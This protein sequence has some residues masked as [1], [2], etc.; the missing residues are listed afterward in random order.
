MTPEGQVAWEYFKARP[1]PGFK[2][3]YSVKDDGRLRR[4]D[5][6]YGRI[7]ALIC[8]DADYPQLVAQ[9]GRLNADIVVCAANDWAE[10]SPWHSRMASFRSIKQGFNQIRAAS[11]AVSETYDYQ[12]HR[13]AA[14]DDALTDNKS[15]VA[16]VPTKGVHTIYSVLGDWFAWLCLAGL[17]V[18][19]LLSLI[20]SKRKTQ[21]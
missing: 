13:L 6:P 18:L 1:V 8:A 9:A 17:L 12:G 5:T 4:I 19:V 20:R 21:G 3:V 14:V 2:A 15:I 11:N 7:S 10:I 16:Y